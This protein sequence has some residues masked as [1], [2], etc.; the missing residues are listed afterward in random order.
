[1]F[2]KLILLQG[3]RWWAGTQTLTPLF[4]KTSASQIVALMIM[5]ART[6]RHAHAHLEGTENMKQ[7]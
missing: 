5:K 7:G 1:M 2:F 6:H 3:G 4:I